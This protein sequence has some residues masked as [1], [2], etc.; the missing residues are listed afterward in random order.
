MPTLDHIGLNRYIYMTASADTMTL[1]SH[2]V[3][4]FSN[5]SGN[6]ILGGDLDDSRLLLGINLYKNGPYG[7]SS[8][9]QLRLSEN[10]LSRHLRKNNQFPIVKNGKQRIFFVDG[11]SQ[12]VIDRYGAQLV[13]DEPAVVS[14][15]KPVLLIGTIDDYNEN[16]GYFANRFRK[17]I[18]LNNNIAYFTNDQINNIA[19]VVENEDEFYDILKSYYLEAVSYTHLTLP[20]KRIV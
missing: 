15:Y 3:S 19:G 12:V 10:P 9:Q 7:H 4:D 14:S 20:T 1:G 8:W 18:S 13:L 11:N 5:S 6:A 16:G 17:K 2:T